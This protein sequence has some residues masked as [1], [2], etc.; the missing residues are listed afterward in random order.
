MGLFR[1]SLYTCK[2]IHFF[3]LIL[4]SLTLFG[5]SSINT[6]HPIDQNDPALTASMK[7]YYSDD[8][9]SYGEGKVFSAKIISF[10]KV[11][12][13]N[14]SIYKIVVAIAPKCITEIDINGFTFSLSEEAEKYFYTYPWLSSYDLFNITMF[15]NFPLDKITAVSNAQAYCFNLT[16]DN[17]DNG[18][19][20]EAGYTDE[21][22]D[23]LVKQLNITINYNGTKDT[24]TL[25][26]QNEISSYDD[27]N[28]I[29]ESRED[30]LSIFSTGSDDSPVG[31]YYNK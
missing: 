8:T 29:P 28:T 19:Q 20:K 17:C 24:I 14:Q 31:G 18:K 13:S 21:E 22:F 23:E 2:L 3:A 6:C 15:D 11:I 16:F 27:I 4:L 12:R 7:N 30:L 1:N 26:Y 25:E 5:C 9:M 10:D